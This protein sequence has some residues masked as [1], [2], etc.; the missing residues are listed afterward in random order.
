MIFRKK[1]KQIE[2]EISQENKEELKILIEYIIEA[3][4]LKF[5]DEMI[6]EKFLEKNYPKE[7]IIKAFNTADILTLK[8]SERRNNMTKEEETEFEDDEDELESEED[9]DDSDDEEEE[10]E[11]KPKKKLKKTKKVKTLRKEQQVTIQ[12]IVT[13]HEQRIQALEAKLFRMLSA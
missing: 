7:L 10:I 12:D 8:K 11:E 6:M 2:K 9:I 5:G 4:N 3:R 13:N 1:K